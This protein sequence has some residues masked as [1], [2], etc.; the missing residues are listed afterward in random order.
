M[1]SMPVV[2]VTG[3]YDQKIRFWDASSGLNSKSIPFGDS[4]V[5]CLCVSADKSI[6]AAGGNP[7]VNLFDVNG[8]SER[9]VMSC[10]G[11]TS[12]VMKVGFQKDQKWLYT[13]SEDGTVR[14]WDSRS[15][16]CSRKYECNSPVNSVI[17]HPCQAELISGD[18]SGSVKIWDLEADKCREEF[19]PAVD[20]PVRSLSISSNATTLA[21][22]THKGRLFTYSMNDAKS[23]EATRDFQAH[24]D[25][26][27]HCLISPNHQTIATTSA[28]KTIKLWS[29]TS[30]QSSSSNNSTTPNTVTGSN[31]NQPTH[32]NINPNVPNT[33]WE[34]DQTLV[35]HQRWVWDCVFSADSMYLISASSD[36]SA[37]LW[38]L[39][40]GEVVRN[41][42]G[43]NMTV[44]C[45][46]LNDLPPSQ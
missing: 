19:I 25:Y 18:Q 36:H 44:S 22:A 11:H 13:G 23:W 20:I 17:L 31:S 28:D 24:E 9:P 35:K 5:N 1:G 40:T 33:S 6:I 41:Y 46:A 42:T 8:S 7:H 10:D 45:V 14:I 38:D 32:F 21:V 3:G 37:K 4:Q 27:L 30:S 43:H 34:L 2:L 12:N 29:C 15:N 39:S 16:T 26:L